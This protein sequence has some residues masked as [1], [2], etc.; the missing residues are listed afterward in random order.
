M[1]K[2]LKESNNQPLF[3]I[4]MACVLLCLAFQFGFDKLPEMTEAAIAGTASVLFSAV[5]VMLA[6]LIPQDIKHKLVFTRFSNEMPACRIHKHAQ[7]DC[8]INYQL[9]M[10]KWPEVFDDKISDAERNTLW[11]HQI[12]KLVDSNQAIL[13]SHQG[14]LLYRDAF[15]GLV[16]ISLCVVA[17]H[18][19]GDH[20]LLGPFKSSVFYTLGGFI[21][22]SMMAARS[23]GKRFVTNAVAAAL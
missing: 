4:M 7:K 20:A 21:I 12:Y 18:F 17:W 19:F 10:S 8:R 22:L 11:Y 23:A 16:M 15:A 13:Q 5:L 9:A 2:N 6:N 14:F 3:L 1:A